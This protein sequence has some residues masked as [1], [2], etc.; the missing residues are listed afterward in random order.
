MEKEYK[1]ILEIEVNLLYRN[2]EKYFI[3][4]NNMWFIWCNEKER[5]ILEE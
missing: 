3:K 4:Y 5:Y 2:F 1:N